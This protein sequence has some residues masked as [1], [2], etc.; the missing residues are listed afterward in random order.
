MASTTVQKL[1]TISGAPSLPCGRNL[2][3]LNLAERSRR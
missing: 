1:S 2:D 3:Y